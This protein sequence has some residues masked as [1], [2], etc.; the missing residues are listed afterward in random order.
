M[1]AIVSRLWLSRASLGGEKVKGGL[2]WEALSCGVVP[3]GLRSWLEA[4]VVDQGSVLVNLT[5]AGGVAGKELVDGAGKGN[6]VN[7]NVLCAA[8]VLGSEKSI[9]LILNTC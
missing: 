6:R 4:V 5:G 1:N 8:Q 7:A 2:F 3:L 9:W